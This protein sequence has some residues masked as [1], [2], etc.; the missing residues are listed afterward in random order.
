[1]VNADDHYER[2]YTI[3]DWYDGPR[4]GIADF[5]GEPHLYQCE[6]GDEV[7]G[8]WLDTFLLM[9]VDREAFALALEDYA[10]YLRWEAACRAGTATENTHPALPED[11]RRHDEI[12]RSLAG[13]LALDP[14]KA[15]RANADFRWRDDPGR[16]A[17]DHRLC[18]V[19][20][21]PVK[22]QHRGPSPRS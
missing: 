11:R 9:P 13:R 4:S 18:E 19:K 2:C 20:W 3:T 21:T 5:R 15:V 16:S 10:I 12:E 14:A 6:S 22:E 8:Y 7:P 1:M 17:A